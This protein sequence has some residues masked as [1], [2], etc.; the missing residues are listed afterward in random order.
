MTY[1]CIMGID[2]GFGGGIAF[3]Y[4]EHP[5]L[6]SCYDMPVMDREVD[7]S[8]VAD[9]IRQHGPDVAIIEA[10]SSRP[11]QGVVS[12]FS[13]G[14][15]YGVVRGVVSACKISTILVS[16]QKWKKAMSLDSDKEK[17]RKM[18]IL[19]FPESDAF[20][21]KKSH[22]RAEAALMALYGAQTQR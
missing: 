19:F 11:K 14:T 22:G 1:K 9:L 2:P 7:G 21:L 20:R 6:I 10:V 3:Y 13:F 12:V 15:S 5:K 16:P 18:A 8:A 17:S 4:P